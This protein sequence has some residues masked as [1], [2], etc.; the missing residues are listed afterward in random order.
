MDGTEVEVKSVS[1]VGGNTIALEIE[2]PSDF[3]AR[4]GQFLQVAGT[5]DDEEITRHYTLSS[6]DAEGTFEI[7]V[8]VDPDG[9]L[10]PWLAAR[11]AGETVE[12]AGPFGRSY[13]EG[14]PSVVVLAGGP[15]VGPAVGIGERALAEGGDVTIVYQDDAPVH[16]GRLR[17]LEAGGATVVITDEP[18]PESENARTVLAR[19]DGQVF[20]Y[21][22]TPFL[23]E[24]RDVL[25]TVGHDPDEAKS[26]NFG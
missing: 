22:F 21:G 10:G 13:Y 24:A 8:A 18:L 17:E 5:V 7:T 2:A 16:E 12:I 20:I 6:P 14:E 11:S 25:A 26:E 23:T 15:G 3:S 1:N 9:E 4:P 19:A